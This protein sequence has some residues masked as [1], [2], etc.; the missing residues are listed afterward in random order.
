MKRFTGIAALILALTLSWSGPALAGGMYNVMVSLFPSEYNSNI[1]DARDSDSWGLFAGSDDFPLLFESAAEGAGLSWDDFKAA[2]RLDAF[3]IEM[4]YSINGEISPERRMLRNGNTPSI[5]QMSLETQM[6]LP[7]GNMDI[8]YDMRI[9]AG[10]GGFAFGMDRFGDPENAMILDNLWNTGWFMLKMFADDPETI[11]ER[12]LTVESLD[13][14]FYANPTPV[15]AAIWLLGSGL[16]SLAAL[17]RWMA[18][19]S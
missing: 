3:F 1:F 14:H 13:I 11:D 17:R 8:S 16:A 10:S 4:T 6:E 12:Y 2:N 7:S 18:S 9:P 5:W 19:Q 15:P